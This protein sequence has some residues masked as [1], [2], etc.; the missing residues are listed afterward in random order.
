MIWW[1]WLND[2]FFYKDTDVDDV[3]DDDDDDLIEE[4]RGII[5][6]W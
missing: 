5:T 1:Q 4:W 3:D 6:I 2:C